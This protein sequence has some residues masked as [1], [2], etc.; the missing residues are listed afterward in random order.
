MT[1]YSN[2]Q[3][4]IKNCSSYQNKEN[5]NL[6]EKGQLIDVN[7]NITLFL[8]DRKKETAKITLKSIWFDSK[9]YIF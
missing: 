3:V 1:Y 9:Q 4:S 8:N 5:L 7:T 2:F 6:N